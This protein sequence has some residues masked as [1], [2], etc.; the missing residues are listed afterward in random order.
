MQ[1][2]EERCFGYGLMVFTALVIAFLLPFFSE[3][4]RQLA[5]GLACFVLGA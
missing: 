2:K 3:G 4:F 1:R 5:F